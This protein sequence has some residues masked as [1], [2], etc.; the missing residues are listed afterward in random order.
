V[1]DKYKFLFA[2]A[3]GRDQTLRD[4]ARATSLCMSD[5]LRRLID[6]AARD[7]TLRNE[8][9]P[10]CSGFIKLEGF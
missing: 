1:A 6:R 8:A 2:P 7:E 3:E 4:L 5:V 9:F 10:E